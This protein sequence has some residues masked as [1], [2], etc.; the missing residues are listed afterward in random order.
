MRNYPA[1]LEVKLKARLDEERKC[2]N[3]RTYSADYTAVVVC[4]SNEILAD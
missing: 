4:L 3:L 1:L 2:H